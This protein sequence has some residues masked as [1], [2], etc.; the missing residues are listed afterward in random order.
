MLK[1]SSNF[2]F[3]ASCL[4]CIFVESKIWGVGQ[5]RSPI[6]LMFVF[7]ILYFDVLTELHLETIY[8]MV[9]QSSMCLISSL[10]PFFSLSL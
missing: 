1:S 7:I 10:F 2:I 4:D 3:R 8:S 6:Q 9:E 5:V